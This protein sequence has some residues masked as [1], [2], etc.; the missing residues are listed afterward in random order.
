MRAAAEQELRVALSELEGL[1]WAAEVAVVTCKWWVV[2][3]VAVPLEA[4]C[5]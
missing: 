2:M 5:L 3:I 4:L 1:E